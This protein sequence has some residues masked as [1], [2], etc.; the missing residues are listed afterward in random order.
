[1]GVSE[2]LTRFVRTSLE[3]G[4]ERERIEAV[5]LAAG[6]REE[7]VEEALGAFAE[8]DFAVPVPRP[9]AYLSPREAFL[10]LLLFTTLYIS[11]F[12]L[13]GLLFEL[14]EA[15]V[16]DPADPVRHG[17]DVSWHVAN[18]VVAFP[19]YVLLARRQEKELR[20]D[21]AARASKVRKWLTY[22]TLFV[23]AGFLIG[24]LVALV[25]G[26]LEGDLTLR[27]FLNVLVVAAIAGT[28]FT[29]YLRDLRRDET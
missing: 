29:Y 23:A 6:W 5:L 2:E 24:D 20:D 16:P 4:V 14:I 21:P 10:Y 28:V 8:S 11:A 17:L 25:Y 1:M 12:N 9:R 13:G 22:G 27:F 19:V 15:A 18:L 7:R 26:F 3:R